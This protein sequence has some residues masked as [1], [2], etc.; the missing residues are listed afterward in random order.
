MKKIIRI[1]K[2]SVKNPEGVNIGSVFIGR[3][4][5]RDIESHGKILTGNSY[6]IISKNNSSVKDLYRDLTTSGYAGIF[7][8]RS[9]I[10]MTANISHDMNSQL[11]LL[12][13]EK[14]KG[15]QTI[16]NPDELATL[17]KEISLRNKKSIIVIDGAHYF[18]TK[19][20]FEK[21][22]DALYKINDLVLKSQL[23]V[24]LRIDPSIVDNSQMAIFENEFQLLPSQKIEGLI[25]D[26]VLYD[27]L[28][29]V[30]E[31]NQS[32]SMVSIK[33]IINKS[34]VA[35][36]TAAKR[37]DLLEEKGLIFIK[38]QGKFQMVYL[39]EKGKALMHKRQ[40]V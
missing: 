16:A 9:S 8:S 25:L 14:I 33:K 18:I 20:S 37:L 30:Y 28:K 7:I 26:D 29:Y 40:T 10:E 39:T 36:S 31:E 17:V 15:F 27:M 32:N 19:F 35:Y 21:F 4:I 34:N 3:D 24:L 2:S 6:L 13:L 22:I 23:I 11:I 5:T 12:S 1:S 38:K